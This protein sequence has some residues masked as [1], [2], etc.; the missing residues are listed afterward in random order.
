VTA[1]RLR[2][3]QAVRSRSKAATAI[4]AL[5]A[6]VALL[7]L[8]RWHHALPYSGD[9]PHYLVI[10]NSIVQDGDVDVKNDY[11][12]QRYL[13]YMHAPIDPHVN[14]SIFGANAPHWYSQHG[15][16][17]PALLV[18]AVVLDGA[19]GAAAT[20][21]LV[22]ALVLV[23]AY[24]WVGR[25]T[26][27]RSLALIATAA[28]GVSAFF[29][30]LEGR[31]FPDLPTAALLLGCLLLLELPSARKLHLLLLAA[32]VA[33]SP[34]FHFKNALPF[35]TVLAIAA[36]RVVRTARGGERVRRVIL[37]TLPVVASAIGYEC[38]VHT[39]YGSWLP[40]RM[41]PP[42]NNAFALDP[43]RAMA[44][45]S[46]DSERGLFANNPA[47]LLILAGLPVW[48]RQYRGPFLRLALVLGPTIL[49]QSTFNDWSGG[50][51]PRARY[52]L[53]FVPA[54]LP[55]VA[56]FLKE[57][58]RAARRVVAVLVG[59]Q[60]ALALAFVSLHPSWGLTGTRSPLFKA[61]DAK[62]GIAL[63]RAMP[64]FDFR[65]DLTRGDWQLAAWVVAAGI[66]LA[67][68]AHLALRRTPTPALEPAPSA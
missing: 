49:V 3:P 39:W 36:V 63:D 50:Y 30:A 34:W 59:L 18:P 2:P 25:F 45:M 26:R 62:L 29:L 31:I 64:T 16:G 41:F 20:M 67:Y 52:A 8:V 22:A 32:L 35:A 27:E 40:T 21:V 60:A 68:G 51:A 46:F 4:A 55:A 13:S 53:Q 42:G 11:L 56:L 12:Q 58:P 48:L 37:L 24:L 38:A 10:A 23:L 6:I 15:V 61:I 7:A 28:L 43:A 5:L 19:R 9:E 33:A 54:L 17:L 14:T 44:A 57:A 1:A 65:A 47:L 66:S